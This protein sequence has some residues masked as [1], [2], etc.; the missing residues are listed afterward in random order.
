MK[1]AFTER[2]RL[3]CPKALE[4]AEMYKGMSTHICLRCGNLYGLQKQCCGQKTLLARTIL[5]KLESGE[6]RKLCK[7]GLMI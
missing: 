5:D 7:T 2:R 6:L 1:E 4:R 3:V